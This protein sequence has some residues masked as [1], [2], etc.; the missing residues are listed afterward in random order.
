MQHSTIHLL[1]VLCDTH[2]LSPKRQRAMPHALPLFTNSF[3]PCLLPSTLLLLELSICLV[4]LCLNFLVLALGLLPSPFLWL[5]HLTFST[6]MMVASL[7]LACGTVTKQQH[8]NGGGQF[9]K[10]CVPTCLVPPP[11]L[12][13]HQPL[14]PSLFV[15][16]MTSSQSSDCSSNCKTTTQHQ[17]QGNNFAA[18]NPMHQFTRG[19]HHADH[20]PQRPHRCHVEK[21]SAVMWGGGVHKGPHHLLWQRT[22]ETIRG[23]KH[24][25]PLIIELGGDP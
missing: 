25:W 7:S 17:T 12:H 20:S 24:H 21:S 3:G 22:N 23:M 18:K 13:L 5:L 1:Q 16:P 14:C 9:C 8:D 10:K 19:H 4:I 6:Q 2:L 15:S 11:L